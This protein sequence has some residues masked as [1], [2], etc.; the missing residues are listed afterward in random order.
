M[1]CSSEST[2]FLSIG[3]IVFVFFYVSNTFFPFYYRLNI[4]LQIIDCTTEV[5]KFN[6]IFSLEFSNNIKKYI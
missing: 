4:N 5:I 3:N 6:H 2:F 1:S